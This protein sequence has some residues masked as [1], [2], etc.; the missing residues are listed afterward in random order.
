MQENPV[1]DTQ[2]QKRVF[3]AHVRHVSGTGLLT[4]LAKLAELKVEGVLTDAV[5]VSEGET[6]GLTWISRNRSC[7]GVGMVFSTACADCGSP[8]HSGLRPAAPKV[9]TP[10]RVYSNC[11]LLPT[12][13]FI[14]SACR[15]SRVRVAPTSIG[16]ARWRTA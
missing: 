2:P 12:D 4:S 14:P 16:P 1:Q 9:V 8:D 6:A 11:P 10:F 5:R 3:D 7:P 13:Q 15:S